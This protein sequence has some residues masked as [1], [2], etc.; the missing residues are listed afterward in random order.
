MRNFIFITA[1]S[2]ITITNVYCQELTFKNLE[3][4]WFYEKESI[5]MICTSDGISHYFSI[6]PKELVY[7]KYLY[8]FYDN[9]EPENIKDLESKGTGKYFFMINLGRFFLNG[10][11]D[12]KTVL[13]NNCR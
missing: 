2:L 4:I 6:C 1:F 5:Y 3:G 10:F 13:I 7:Q 8:G 11:D 12:F 9:C